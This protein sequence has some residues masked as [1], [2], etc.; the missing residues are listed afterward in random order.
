MNTDPRNADFGKIRIGNTRVDLAGG[1]QQPLRLLAQLGSGEIVSSTSG[2]LEHLS[3]GGFGTSRLD[4]L[5][6]F[7]RG[8]LAPIPSLGADL[9]S[10]SQF[11]GIPLDFSPSPL[12][13]NSEISSHYMPLLLQDVESLQQETHNPA[14]SLGGGLL[15]AF[16]VGVQSYGARKKKVT[17]GSGYSGDSGYAG[18]GD[19]S[20]SSGYATGGGY[21][22]GTGYGP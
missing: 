6:Q 21:A 11:A 4:V 2:K 7:A 1:F 16:G 19:Y 18:G 10:G 3:G 20:G 15:S 14:A 12:D 22:S 17:G 8:K 5:Q 9:L 13:P